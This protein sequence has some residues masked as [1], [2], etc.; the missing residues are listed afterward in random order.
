MR[1][2]PRLLVVCLV[3]GAAAACSSETMRFADNPFQNPFSNSARLDPGATGSVGPARTQ[4]DGRAKQAQSFHG[5]APAGQVSSA[6]LAAPV[7]SA[8]IAS[9]PVAAPPVRMT[10]VSPAGLPATGG[11][12]GWTAQGGSTVALGQGET[13]TTLSNRYGVPEAA[14]RSANGIAPGAR[15]APGSQLIIPVYNAAGAAAPAAPHVASAPAPSRVAAPSVQP[16]PAPQPQAVAAAPKAAPGKARMQLVQ[17]AKATQAKQAAAAPEEAAPAPAA[18]ARIA[19]AKP[20]RKVEVAKAEPKAPAKPEQAKIVAKAP[21]PVAVA[22]PAVVAAAPAAAPAAAV[23]KPAPVKLAKAVEAPAKVAVAAPAAVQAPAPVAAP[24][25]APAAKA[26]PAET[27]SIAPAGRGGS[28]FRWPARGRIITGY[29]KSGGNDG[30][31]I[32]LPEG[33]PVK[34]AEGGEVAYAGN[35]LKGY[36]NLVLVRHPDGWVSAYAH[37]GE[38]KV[39]RGDKIARGQLLALSGQSG[40]VSSPQLHFELRKGSTPVDPMPHLAGN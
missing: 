30:I 31:N 35:E 26:E 20:E 4:A 18:P 16:A 32:S 7:A 21:A 38:L 27:A 24:A 19:S 29:N 3:G 37:N 14:I 36:G 2:V 23:V 12:K 25:A 1:S 15:P 33:T 17:G 22:K 5:V 10:N 28:E 6:P 11:P 39:K 9:A 34:A 8:P 13:I 40:N